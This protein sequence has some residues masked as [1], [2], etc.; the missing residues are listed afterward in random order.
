MWCKYN[1]LKLCITDS[2][3]EKLTKSCGL[4]F[5][6]FESMKLLLTFILIGS[7]ALTFSQV[8]FYMGD[9]SLDSDIA[10]TVRDN[11]VYS[12]NGVFNNMV[13]LRIENN[14]VYQGNSTMTF[15][16]RYTI[17]DDKVYRG[18]SAFSSDIIYTI[19]DN[20]V[21]FGNSSFSTDC[22]F[23]IG[24]DNSLSLAFIAC[25]VGPY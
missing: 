11:L 24:G 21:Y 7:S 25:I 14:K 13:L 8:R 5:A 16:C 6:T 2:D 18:S 1:G 3:C 23:T 22:I 9:S 17:K 15:D 19:S 20:K 10:Y 12:G 4:F